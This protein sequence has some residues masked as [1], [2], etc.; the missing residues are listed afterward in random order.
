[1]PGLGSMNAETLGMAEAVMGGG[2]PG[3]RRFRGAHLG[4]RRTLVLHYFS[5]T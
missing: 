3:N 1:M 2:Y 5:S 4:G